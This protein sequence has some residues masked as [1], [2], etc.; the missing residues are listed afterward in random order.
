[1]LFKSILV[2]T[3][4]KVLTISVGSIRLRQRTKQTYATKTL[5]LLVKINKVLTQALLN[6]KA[7]VNVITKAVVNKLRLLVCTDLLLALKAILRD[8]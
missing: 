8:I 1:L 4:A 2:Q 7:K 5:K 6:T 3:K